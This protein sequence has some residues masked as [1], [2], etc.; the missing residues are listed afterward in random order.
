MIIQITPVFTGANAFSEPIAINN[1]TELTLG[2]ICAD[3]S[4][5]TLTL[6]EA[7]DAAY[8]GTW[9]TQSAF[10]HTAPGAGNFY[11]KKTAT[12]CGT[13]VR[14]RKTGITGTVTPIIFAKTAQ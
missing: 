2:A 13:F 8:T 3:W 11:K 4:A 6:E 10:S 14:V 7:H 5:G 12:V 1:V 9:E